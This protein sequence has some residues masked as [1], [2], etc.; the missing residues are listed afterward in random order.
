VVVLVYSSVKTKALPIKP[1][2]HHKFWH[3]KY[4]KL[5]SSQPHSRVQI[6]FYLHPF[7]VKA[8]EYGLKAGIL[9]LFMV[10][11]QQAI[12]RS[13]KNDRFAIFQW[14]QQCERKICY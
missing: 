5:D 13:H 14:R 2:I 9:S 7:L 1:Q 3:R 4:I 11:D 8:R 6:F 10:Q 12:S